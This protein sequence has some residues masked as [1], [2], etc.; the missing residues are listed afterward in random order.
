[1]QT[2][3]IIRIENNDQMLYA[4]TFNKIDYQLESFD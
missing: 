4:Y 2:N 3:Q 1:M